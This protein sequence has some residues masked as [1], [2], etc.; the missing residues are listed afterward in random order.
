MS[1]STPSFKDLTEAY[2]KHH[3]DDESADVVFQPL[4]QI[5]SDNTKCNVLLNNH[6]TCDRKAVAI[7]LKRQDQIDEYVNGNVVCQGHLNLVKGAVNRFNFT[8]EEFNPNDKHDT[9]TSTNISPTSTDPK[10]DS[11]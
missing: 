11:D 1:D 8:I 3:I 10:S 9:S 4:T 5:Q 7:L 6:L 2:Y